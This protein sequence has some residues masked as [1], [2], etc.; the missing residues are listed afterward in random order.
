MIEI[1]K[2]V[3]S[4]ETLKKNRDIAVIAVLT[5]LL[6]IAAVSL[7]GKCVA[8]YRAADK[9]KLQMSDMKSALK[10]WETKSTF[11]N[12]QQFRPVP[13]DKVDSVQSDIMLAMQNYQLKLNDYKVIAAQAK[14]KD[15][16]GD[17]FKAF[18]IGFAGSYENTVNFIENFRAR[19]AL[20]RIVELEMSPQSGMITTKL[21]YRVYTK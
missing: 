10:D 11:L 18:E 12:Q 2:Q 7:A 14:S 19:D 8:D 3:F 13:A 5:I 17:T 21:V 9:V 15:K 4:D 20:I 16:E 1:L 6:G